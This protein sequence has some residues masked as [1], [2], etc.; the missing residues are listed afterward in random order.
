MKLKRKVKKLLN[1]KKEKKRP[2]IKTTTSKNYLSSIEIL[3]FSQNTKFNTK[4]K[5]D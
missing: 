3:T 4:K 1:R 5:K 2:K